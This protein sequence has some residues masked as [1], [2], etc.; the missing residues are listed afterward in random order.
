MKVR[1]VP[2]GWIVPGCE[3]T[4]DPLFV[5]DDPQEIERRDRQWAWWFYN[6]SAPEDGR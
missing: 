5:P 3:Y 6:G 2:G 4:D 1:K